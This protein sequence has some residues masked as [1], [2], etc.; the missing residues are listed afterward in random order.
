MLFIEIA[1]HALKIILSLF[2][3]ID[4]IDKFIVGDIILKCSWICLIIDIEFATCFW[5][6]N[7]TIFAEIWSKMDLKDILTCS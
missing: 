2:Y 3:N 4:F 5:K 6:A 1:F 7:A